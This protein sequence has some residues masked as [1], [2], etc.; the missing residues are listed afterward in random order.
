[1]RHL[2]LCC[3]LNQY[4]HHLLPSR[5][6]F[7]L[8]LGRPNSIRSCLACRYLVTVVSRHMHAMM[9]IFRK[10]LVAEGQDGLL[11]EQVGGRGRAGCCSNQ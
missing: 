10:W 11:Q 3:C 7:N 6:H 5:R 1:M 4:H 2:S 9:P 8:Q